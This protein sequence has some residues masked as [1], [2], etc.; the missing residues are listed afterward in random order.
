LDDERGGTIP[1]TAWKMKR[2]RQPWYPGETVSVAIG[3]GYVTVTPLQMA[4]MMA[5]VANGGK[6]FRPRIVSKVESV[7]GTSVREYGPELIRTIE[8][9]PDTLTRVRSALADVVKGGTGG[10]ARS[11]IVDIAGKTGTAQVVEMKGGYVKSEQ[12]SYFSRDHAWFVAYA[13]VQDPQI[14]IAVLIEHGGHGGDAA[15]PMAKK[16]FEKFVEQ[17]KQNTEKQQVHLDGETRAD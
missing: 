7:D 10:M 3:Q 1:D 14:A 11:P 5:T 8:I 15:A 6:L 16:V 13:P 12:L 17:E 2:F 9:K 4:N